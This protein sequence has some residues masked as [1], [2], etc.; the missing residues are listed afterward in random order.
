MVALPYFPYP[1]PPRP[2]PSAPSL[3]LALGDP[4]Q[5]HVGCVDHFFHEVGHVHIPLKGGQRRRVEWG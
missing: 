5:G 2:S 1:P 3:T 4:L